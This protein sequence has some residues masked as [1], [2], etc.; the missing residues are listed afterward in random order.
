VFRSDFVAAVVAILLGTDGQLMWAGVSGLE[1]PLSTLCIV[2]L[3]WAAFR[4]GAELPG[5]SAR[6]ALIAV[7]GII[8]WCRPDLLPAAAGVIAFVI[9]EGVLRR[10][11]SRLFVSVLAGVAMAVGVFSAIAIYQH[12]TGRPLPSSFYA[13]VPNR[14]LHGF[15]PSALWLAGDVNAAEI[16]L[17][18]ATLLASLSRWLRGCD[19]RYWLLPWLP[20]GLFA[21][22]KTMSYPVLG[23][24]HRYITP[25]LPIVYCFGVGEV[26]ELLRLGVGRAGTAAIGR[27]L[28][29]AVVAL[30]FVVRYEGFLRSTLPDVTAWVRVRMQ[31]DMA[32]GQWIAANTPADAVIASEPIGTIKM[33]SQRRTID[34]VG[35]TSSAYMGHYPDW[36]WLLE[37]VRRDGA[38]YLVYYPEWF[39]DTTGQ[40]LPGGLEPVY[41]IDITSDRHNP[42]N[43][44]GSTPIVVYR[45][46]P[47][48]DGR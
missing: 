24:E 22:A 21:L 11:R 37:H 20:I 3:V 10:D 8:W 40:T 26:V 48:D 41:S 16:A 34:V 25:L 29:G 35:L 36:P 46:L 31:G 42:P 27:P 18:G 15:I 30:C 38:D 45:I 28:L 39:K 19:R 5:R 47:T 32:V 4:L 17:Y 13:K 7:A 33:Y 9:I 23:Q 14:N 44:I 43:A 2:T 6:L 12:F 1:L